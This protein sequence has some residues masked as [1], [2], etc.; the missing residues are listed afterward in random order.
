MSR[1]GRSLSSVG[2]LA[3]L[4]ARAE[5]PGGRKVMGWHRPYKPRNYAVG[6]T[7]LTLRY[8]TKLTQIELA[9]QVGVSKRSVLNWEGGASYPKE[10]HL[11]RLI[12]LFVAEGVFTP[13]D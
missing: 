10:G 12:A 11:R 8:R 9:T 4:R 6:Q 13:G 2:M 7:L 3:Y 5:A 1:S